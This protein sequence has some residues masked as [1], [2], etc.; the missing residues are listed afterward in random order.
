M[1]RKGRN[2]DTSTAVTLLIGHNQPRVRGHTLAQLGGHLLYQR[3][4]LAECV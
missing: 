2:L 1:T 3:R 4:R